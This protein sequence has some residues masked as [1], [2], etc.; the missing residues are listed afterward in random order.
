M[1]LLPDF[2]LLIAPAHITCSN[3][4][5]LSKWE[6]NDVQREIYTNNK[7]ERWKLAFAVQDISIVEMCSLKQHISNF[8]IDK[9]DTEKYYYFCL[10]PFLL[11]TNGQIDSQQL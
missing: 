3:A 6:Y 5:L 9:I 4:A 11:L 2:I 10:N 7:Y 1:W 8:S